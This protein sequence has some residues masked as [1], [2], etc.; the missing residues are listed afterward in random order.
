LIGFSK[1]VGAFSLV[2]T[3]TRGILLEE[4]KSTIAD[5][6]NFPSVETWWTL[7]QISTLKQN[8]KENTDIRMRN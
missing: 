2:K 1:I 7:H 8:K 6:S 4:T 5:L 3:V